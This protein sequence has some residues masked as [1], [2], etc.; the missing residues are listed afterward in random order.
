VPGFDHYVDA[1]HSREWH[2]TLLRAN[3]VIGECP[4]EMMQRAKVR[5]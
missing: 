3:T 1:E 2:Q 5:A 4:V